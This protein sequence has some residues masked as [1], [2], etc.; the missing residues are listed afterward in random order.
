MYRPSDEKCGESEDRS[1]SRT[2]VPPSIETFQSVAGAYLP[3][4]TVAEEYT[5]HLPS[6]E[7]SESTSLLSALVNCFRLLPSA[8]T[9]NRWLRRPSR[10]DAKTRYRPSGVARN[11]SRKGG[12]VV[13]CFCSVPSAFICQRSTWSPVRLINTMRPSGS[14]T[15]PPRPSPLPDVICVAVR[16]SPFASIDHICEMR[17][18]GT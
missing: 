11:S 7:Q 10:F 12:S 14:V 9:R 2:G 17:L 16:E 1:V 18:K 5:T 6:G 13:S 4:T 8:S 15:M 3:L